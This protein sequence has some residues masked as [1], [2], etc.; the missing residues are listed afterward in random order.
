MTGHMIV[1]SLGLV[2]A[3]FRVCV[4]VFKRVLKGQ[5]V[6][7]KSALFELRGESAHVSTRLAATFRSSR[8]L[9]VTLQTQTLPD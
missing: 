5:G 2:F 4:R 8:I 1:G 3:Y 6:W 7:W 9:S